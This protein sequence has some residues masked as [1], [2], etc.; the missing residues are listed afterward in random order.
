MIYIKI[1]EA[2]DRT[3]LALC[4]EDLLGKTFEEHDFIL[5]VK[6]P[7]FGKEKKGKEFLTELIKNASN[8]NA[9]G[10]ETI[11]FCL[12]LKII[13][14]EDIKEIQGIPFVFIFSLQ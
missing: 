9:V 8:I 10:K 14:K 1:H 2:E 5:E 3:I 4:D 13:S 7:F 12:D 6:E 11:Q